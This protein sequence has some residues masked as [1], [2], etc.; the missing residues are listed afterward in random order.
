MRRLVCLTALSLACLVPGCGSDGD[1]P[2]APPAST[3]P[4][5]LGDVAGMPVDETVALTGLQGPV[6]V[7]RD[8]YGRPHIFATSVA[9]AMK[10][11]GFLVAKDRHLQL[12]MLRRAS[13][14]RLAELLGDADASLI[15]TDI[16]FRTVGLHRVAK[17]QYAALAEG[18][19]LKIILDAY[20]D[21][22]NQAYAGIKSGSVKIPS[23]VKKFLASTL[24]EWTGVDSLAMG[25]LQT[26]L[27]S[28]DADD[29]IGRT[30][31]I[32]RIRDTFTTKSADP[33]I[34]KRAAIL[35]DI[36][37][38]A[39]ADPATT[40]TGFPTTKS[41]KTK[42]PRPDATKA[43]EAI[44]PVRD[45]VRRVKDLIAPEGFGSNNWAVMGSR[46]ATGHALVASDPHLSLQSPA[47]FWPV[48]IEVRD[49]DPAKALRV[50]GLAF[51]GIPGIILG[52]NE[53]IAWGATV[54][55]YDVS[56]A[57]AE[58][59]TPDGTAVLF[60]G[61][62]V[63]LT[64][65]DEEI[66]VA[67]R[68]AP[69]L[70]KVHVVPHHGPIE[71]TITIDHQALP[72]DPATGAIS[73]RWTGHEPTEEIAAVVKLL[74]AK[75]VDEA[76]DALAQFGV[77]AQ[78]WMIGDTDGN[79][80]WTSHAKVP[81]RD[82]KSFAWDAAAYDGNLPC[83]VLP[84]DGS[85]E[86]T[87]YLPDELVPWDK[88][89]AAGFIATANNDP[90]GTSLDND[91][92]NDTL[93]DGSPAFLACAWDIG[94]REGRIQ[95]RLSEKSSP[96][97]PEDMADI[98]GDHRSPLG[99]AL[100]SH[101]I[102]A[103]D[104]ALAEKATPGAAADLAT[105]VADPAFSADA[106]TTARGFLDAWGKE[107]DYAATAGV[108]LDTNQIL[109]P[110][111][112]DAKAS[113]ATY[114]FNTWLIRVLAGTIDDEL[115]AANASIDVQ[116]R[117]KSI[118]RLFTL[119]KTELATY[120]AVT[121]DSALWDDLGTPG[122]V[123]SRDD[124]AIRALLE[125][126]KLVDNAGGFE[127][128]RWGRYHSIKFKS[129][130]PVFSN[131]NY[132]DGTVFSS[133][134]RHGDSFVVDACHFSL[135][136][137][138]DPDFSYASGPTQRFVADMDPAG[139]RTWNALPGGNIWDPDSPHHA[140]EVEYWRKNKTHFVPFAVDDV[141]KDKETRTVYLSR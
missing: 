118:V 13:E 1:E 22:V 24:T 50:G 63:K 128:A 38:F 120:D 51:P 57:Y 48:D 75:N 35:K 67:G 40:R 5:V 111:D 44:R 129:L 25:R 41:A 30:V 130:V 113:V 103:I 58:T 92:S 7:V 131:Y 33:A 94:Y 27:L 95:K 4:S 74:R 17:A 73:I 9:D 126:L 56:D 132:P 106:L 102:A 137:S 124:R 10:V 138:K 61:Q 64:T 90:I 140:D 97:T 80:L 107:A 82:P 46:S 49:K 133:F 18:S 59:L 66:R 79:I 93:P 86:W 47:V 54:A 71:P 52:H 11:E 117:G 109:P 2:A 116:D 127:K 12:E 55:G 110:T 139:V 43:L 77:G 81:T 37:R 76:K 89:P 87:G 125:A 105:V 136:G 108:D 91:P 84:G 69:V 98:Q 68:D 34:V 31:S 85:A 114:L 83:F 122:V 8:K 29:E 65:I 14:G 104:R 23:D 100:T 72:P 28:Y 119:P 78:N 15:D 112:A 60:K 96:I 115:K 88:N 6:D 36:A 20:A 16:G 21:G 70:Y 32:Q 26:W 42:G 3:T 62:E 53:H 101:L 123:E 39:P 45:A 135:S 19:E 134:P 121:G 99:A 141:V